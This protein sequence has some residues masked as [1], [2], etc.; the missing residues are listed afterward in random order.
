MPTSRELIE[1]IHAAGRQMVLAITGGGSRAIAELLE[2]PG[3]SATVLEAIVPYSA[4]ALDD[5]LGGPVDHYCSERT[6]RAMAMA[7]FERARELS[8][9]DP[10]QICG[11]GATASLVSNRPKRG[12]HRIHVA[13]Q[14]AE[15][16]SVA[17]CEL[18]KGARTRVEEESTAT[19]LIVKAIAEACDLKQE[20]IPE[21]G[22]S[23][24]VTR[25]DQAAPPLWTQLL[26]GQRTYVD[27]SSESGDFR[28]PPTVLFPGAFN[29]LHSGHRRM[30]QIAA[31]RLGR[32]V[33][34][35]L[36]IT[37]VDKQPL[38]F[39][40][41]AD[42]V[43]QFAGEH[44]LLTRTSRFTGKARLAPGCTFVVGVDTITRVG[45][46]KYY[47]GGDLARD[48]ALAVIRSTGCR[49]LVFGR[50]VGGR[51][52]TLSQLSIPPA[53]RDLCDEVSEHEFRD[54]ISSTTLRNE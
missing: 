43:A 19:A 11:I 15:R 10:H 48:I 7:A 54:D 5:W 24:K 38:D 16:T 35:E 18:K 34:F 31:N 21:H 53:L 41:I 42:R 8:A 52:R 37:N 33:S 22:E 32:P 14:T 26:L 9:N 40:E 12:P 20:N 3:G 6:A 49:F 45:N 39:I 25:R 13:W 47:G 50:D 44:I 28:S 1:H 51:F 29:P 27:I 4:S 30:A 17:T 46:S 36:S 23:E 2:V